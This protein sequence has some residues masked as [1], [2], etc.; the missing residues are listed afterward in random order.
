MK[1]SPAAR[2]RKRRHDRRLWQDPEGRGGGASGRAPADRPVGRVCQR[3]IAERCISATAWARGRVA[4]KSAGARSAGVARGAGSCRSIWPHRSAQDTYTRFP[5][6]VGDIPAIC[7]LL[8][9][10]AKLISA[11]AMNSEQRRL[12]AERVF[13]RIHQAGFPLPRMNR[14]MDCRRDGN[15]GGSAELP[16]A[17]AGV[18][19]GAE[20]AFNENTLQFA[21]T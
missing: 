12:S 21:G 9:I 10:F 1:V 7:S 6:A 15:A 4:P 2:G 17:P 16:S 19:L 18:R 3:W 8:I 14:A 20:I 11:A 5:I 13:E